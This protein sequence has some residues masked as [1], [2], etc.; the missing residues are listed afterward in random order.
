MRERNGSSPFEG[1]HIS[2]FW[3]KGIE[4]VRGGRDDRVAEGTSLLKKRIE[5]IPRVRIPLSPLGRSQV[6]RQRVLVLL[7]GGSSP[8]ALEQNT[9]Y[10]VCPN[11]S[12]NHSKVFT[13]FI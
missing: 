6:V 13:C 1:I 8:P 10:F 11:I 2:L 3:R 5:S 9:R 7:C 12:L 4:I